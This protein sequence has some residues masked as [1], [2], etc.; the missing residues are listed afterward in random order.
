MSVTHFAAKIVTGAAQ[1]ALQVA[2]GAPHFL[3]GFLFGAAEIFAG[4]PDLG[5]V[6]RWA[7]GASDRDQT[8]HGQANDQR[9]CSERLHNSL[10]SY[11]GRFRF[12]RSFFEE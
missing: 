7:I 6:A 12:V 4:S 3:A 2:P 5:P 11:V 8:R 1:L 10:I 9:D